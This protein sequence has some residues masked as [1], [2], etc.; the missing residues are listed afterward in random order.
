[1]R[2]SRCSRSLASSP[3]A[4]DAERSC[5]T[6]GGYSHCR[7]LRTVCQTGSDATC[8]QKNRDT[9]D[10]EAKLFVASKKPLQCRKNSPFLSN[11]T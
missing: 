8:S 1:M 10:R 9:E 7:V 3:A 2:R 6:P 4:A 5:C 11:F